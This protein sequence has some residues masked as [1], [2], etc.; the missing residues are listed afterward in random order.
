[1]REG[2]ARG[3]ME[4]KFSN[5]HDRGRRSIRGKKGDLWEKGESAQ[6]RRKSPENKEKEE[7]E[8]VRENLGAYIFRRKIG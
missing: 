5:K 3:E 7:K 8:N 6:G 4:A 2:W 1:M